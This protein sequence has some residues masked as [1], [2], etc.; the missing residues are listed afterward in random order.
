[1]HRLALPRISQQ[2][3]LTLL[4]KPL[5]LAR[6]SQNIDTPGDILVPIKSPRGAFER[7]FR[8]RAP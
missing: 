4:L 6:A 2:A 1:M 7:A 3:D 5:L 8:F